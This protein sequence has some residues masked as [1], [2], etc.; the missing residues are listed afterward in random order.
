MTNE[1]D[2][3]GRFIRSVF[4]AFE[5]SLTDPHEARLWERD[6]N[7]VECGLLPAL[8]A[9]GGAAWTRD[10]EPTTPADDTTNLIARVTPDGRSFAITP[11]TVADVEG[12]PDAD[13]YDWRGLPMNP[14]G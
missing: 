7:A 13:A 9:L 14:R 10:H 2:T 1:L 4:R 5:A 12:L 6:L 8:R 3:L 11:A